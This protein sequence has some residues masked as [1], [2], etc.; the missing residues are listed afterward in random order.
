LELGCIGDVVK[1]KMKAI[2]AKYPE[3]DFVERAYVSLP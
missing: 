3:Y 2:A 1:E